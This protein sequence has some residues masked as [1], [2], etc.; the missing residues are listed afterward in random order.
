MDI[1][2]AYR[3]AGTLRGAAQIAGTTHKTVKRVIARHEAEGARPARVPRGRNYDGVAVLVAGRVEK[4]AG[5]ISA[6]RLLPA[7]RAAGYAGSDRNFRRLVSEQKALW[8]REHHRGRRPAVW[9]PGEHLVIDWGAEGGLH[10]FCAVLAWSRFRFVRFAGDERA[11]TT[12]AL[13]AECFE[14]LGGVPGK[15]LADRMGCLKGGVV[16]NVVVPTGQYVRFAAH[17]GFRPDFCEAADPESKGIVENLVGYAKADL[18]VAQAPFGDL[19]AANAAA[20][21]WCAEVN[22]A[23]HSEICAVP[24]ERLVTERELL[25]PLPSLRASLGKMVTRKVDRLSCVRFGSARYSVPVRLIGSQVQLR[26][27]D[28]RLLAVVAATGEVVA[29]HVLVA[30]GEA[31]VRDE[32]YGGP[33]AA[34][35]RAAR[36]KTAAEKEFC[37]LGPVAEAFITGAAAAGSTRLGTDLAELNTLRA[38]HRDQAFL[39]A[40]D[41][42]VAFCRWRPADVRSILAAGAGVP[43]PRVPAG[44]ALNLDLPAV[45][46]RPLAD[47]AIGGLS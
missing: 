35:R 38:A 30:P 42:A 20:A 36:P 40:L 1:I 24:A 18:M 23:V 5:R 11:E 37:S 17:Y 8:R 3:E 44:D 47:Y 15:V 6:K 43:E 7:A 34:P 9:S 10:V 16:A 32:H 26:T 29:E 22:G 41:R 2:A 33:R 31:S 4:T 28:G 46:V 25:A 12:L 19:A 14:V 39:A 45:P 21:A 13:L 27:D